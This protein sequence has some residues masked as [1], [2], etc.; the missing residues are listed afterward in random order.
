M[1]K[2]NVHLGEQFSNGLQELYPHVSLPNLMFR[3]NYQDYYHKKI[4]LGGEGMRKKI[5]SNMQKKDGK[6]IK[7]K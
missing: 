4:H 1:P 7:S 5:D 3:Q 2:C 6:V